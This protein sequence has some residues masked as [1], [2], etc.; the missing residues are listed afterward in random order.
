M[1]MKRS[2]EERL[3]MGCSMYTAAKGIV[4]SSILAKNP[5]ISDKEMKKKIFN[6][7]YGLEFSEKQKKKIF[8]V[9]K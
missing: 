3:L 8:A 4:K 7:F 2:G 6:R 5:D 1:I 9:C